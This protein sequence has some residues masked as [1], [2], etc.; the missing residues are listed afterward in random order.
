[1]L[2]GW[3]CDPL[4]EDR[5]MRVP[6]FSIDRVVRGGLFAIIAGILIAVLG[7][8]VVAVVD[9]V[10]TPAPTQQQCADPPCLGGDGL[11]G[12]ADLPMALSMFAYGIAALSGVPVGILALATM[13]R[14]SWR[15][16]I[17]MLI[18]AL[19]PLLVLIGTELVP[20]VVNLCLA[21]HL[22]NLPLPAF[23]T[24]G[25]HG[26]D[27]VDRLHLLQHTIFGA[28]PLGTAYWLALS[29]WYRPSPSLF[30]GRHFRLLRP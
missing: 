22:L 1:M 6:W 25:E 27:V 11:P 3:Q 16:A 26:V 17:R 29:R 12:A 21:A 24:H 30:G 9:P 4:C 2:P 18:P 19:G 15:S 10:A 14:R 20:H 13:A 8:V 5:R 7:S 28:I 23:C